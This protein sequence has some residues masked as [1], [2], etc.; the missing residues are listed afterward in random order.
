MDDCVDDETECSV[1]TTKRNNYIHFALHI[2]V[3]VFLL[4]PSSKY[5]AHE[6][7]YM[8]YAVFGDAITTIGLLFAC[9]LPLNWMIITKYVLFI[10]LVADG[11]TSGISLQYVRRLRISP[12]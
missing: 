4:V 5:E 9:L 10:I 3:V 6:S 1:Q 12:T 11:R 2:F 7:H 8:R